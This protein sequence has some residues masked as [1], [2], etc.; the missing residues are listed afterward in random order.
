MRGAFLRRLRVRN[1]KSFA[2]LDV[3]LEDFN[4]LVGYTASGKSNFVQIFRFLRVVG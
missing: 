3:E 1:F 2:D 4:V